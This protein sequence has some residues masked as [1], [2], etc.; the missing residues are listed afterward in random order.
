[1]TLDEAGRRQEVWKTKHGKKICYHSRVV[2]SL[3][4]KKGKSTGYLVCLECGEAFLD[5]LKQI[6][7]GQSKPLEELA[8]AVR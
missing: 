8:V 5:P 4:S 6:V 1:M 3:V 7:Q 2:D